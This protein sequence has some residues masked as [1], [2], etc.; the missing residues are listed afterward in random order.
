MSACALKISKIQKVASSTQ[1]EI[2]PILT[3]F[4]QPILTSGLVSGTVNVIGLRQG[5]VAVTKKLNAKGR[6]GFL[7]RL[8][9]DQSGNVLAITAASV[10]PLIGVV[11]GAV[12]MSRI[13]LAKSRLQAACDSAVLA[14][15]KAMAG[16]SYTSDAQNRANAMF[17]FN[18]QDANYGTENTTFNSSATNDGQVNGTATTEIPMVLMQ[19]LGITEKDIS[20]TCSAD[21]QVPNID[22]VFVLDVTGSMNDT[23]SGVRK[24]DSLKSATKGFYDTIAAAMVGNTRSQV[25][26]GFVPYSQAVNVSELFVATPDATK[27]E[28]SLVHL[29]DS[30]VVESR[31]AN[32]NTEVEGS[33]WAPDPNST[34][35]SFDQKLSTTVANSRAPDVATSSSPTK[36]SNNDCANYGNN[37]AF[38]I[39]GINVNVFLTPRTSYPGEGVG[40]NVLYKPEGSSTWQATQPTSGDSYI[41]A[42]FNRVSGTWNDNNGAKTSKY[43]E[44]TRKVTHTRYIKASKTYK[45]T[46]WTYKPVTYNSSAYKAG[47]AINY[48]TAI[49][50]DYTVQTAGSYDPVQLRQLPNQTGLTSSS[51]QWSQK[52]IEERDTIAAE[53]FAPIPED[54][55]DLN[56]KTGGI[57]NSLRWR[58]IMR[59]LTYLRSGPAHVT[60]TDDASNPGTACPSASIRNLRT[61]TES[62]F[63]AFVDTLSPNGYTYLDVGMVWGLRLIS[64]QGMWSSRN[65]TGPN[66]GQIARHI[67]FLTDGEPVSAGSTYSA[68]GVEQMSKRITGTTGVAAATLHSRRF[69]ALCDAERG[70]VNIWAVAFGTSVTGNMSNC[71]DPGRAMQANNTAQLTAA[72]TRIANEVADLRLT[73]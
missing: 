62:Q 53:T 64:P 67:I 4:L 38:N 6:G 44:C 18:F 10:I 23:I 14:G 65:L 8:M 41:R 60:T 66:G 37:L 70:A 50:P 72:F 42:T 19:I 25:R 32:F 3:L 27:G 13:Y 28:L 58:P 56:Y 48:V 33:G 36:I 71:A 5:I 57:T 39:G 22:I 59:P 46:N 52:C 9:R 17:G 21:I 55:T 31:V 12:D 35:T 34:P 15:R 40:D 1:S 49:D 26:Y 51:M 45:F 11:G 20:V 43:R 61:Y 73:Q 2:N 16:T 29:A 7:S 63:D 30:M 24:I 54:A 68:Y 69:Q 47:T